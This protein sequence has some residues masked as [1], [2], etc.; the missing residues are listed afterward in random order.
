LNESDKLKLLAGLSLSMGD[1]LIKPLT[2][3]QIVEKG[4]EQYNLYLMNLVAEPQDFNLAKDVDMT[5]IFTWDIILSNMYY[6]TD[7]YRKF[8]IEALQ[9]FL[10]S[11]V[12]FISTQGFFHIGESIWDDIKKTCNFNSLNKENYEDFKR[13]LKSQNCLDKEKKDEFANTANSKAEEIK[14]KILKGRQSIQGAETK[15]SFEDLISVLAANGN[16]LNILNVWDV[17][18]VQFNNQFNRMQMVESYDINIRYILAG[19]KPDEIQLKH[20]CRPIE[21]N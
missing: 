7:E 14:R 2:L 8:L 18:L 17:T 19:A 11:K 15:V 3:R 4:Y 5:N 12:R 6:G 10:N 16:N 13:I 1:I 9:L 20:Y 21:D